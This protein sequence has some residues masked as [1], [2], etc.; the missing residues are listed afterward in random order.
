MGENAI[1]PVRIDLTV[2]IN[3]VEESGLKIIHQVR[4]Q[5]KDEN[6][7]IKPFTAGI[8]NKIIGYN[9]QSNTSYQMLLIRVYGQSTELFIDRQKEIDNMLLL[10]NAGCAPPLYAIFN[11]GLCYG[12]VVGQ[13][14]QWQ[15]MSDAAV[16]Q[17]TAKEVAKIHNISTID[18][19]IQPVLFDTLEKFLSLVPQSFDDPIKNQKFKTQCPNKSA[20]IEEVK[21]LQDVLLKHDAPIVYCHNDLLC[22][23]IVYN[24]Q[25]ESVTFID[26]EYG[27][28]NYAPY[29]IADHFCEFAGVD[30]VDYNRYP[31]KEF[32]LQWLSIYLQERAKLAGKDE[33][34]T[35]SQIHQL[36][37]QVNQFA[38]ASHYLWGIWSLIQAKNSLIDFDF[39]QYGITRFNE[40]YSKKAL[41]L[42]LA[43]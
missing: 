28:F 2:D 11:N 42:S 37:V 8:T 19:D 14:L 24:K 21:M 27:G 25:N 15:Q 29:D 41:F 38:L 4:P 34:I 33:T 20:L 40:Y 39:L 16:Y 31:Q 26:Y 3:N 36:Y 1:I 12:F 6:I 13:P 23:N 43:S 10:H 5:W 35:Q 30:E 32:Q 7:L 22:Q 9:L 18:Q 17:L